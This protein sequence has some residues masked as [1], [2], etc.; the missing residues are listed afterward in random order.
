VSDTIQEST[1]TGGLTRPLEGNT[2]LLLNDPGKVWIVETGSVDL[3]AV[4][5]ADGGL[6]SARH[7]VV[8]A[9]PGAV[10]FGLDTPGS[11]I[12][13][14]AVGTVGTTIRTLA[15]DD[16]VSRATQ[17]QPL[18]A[19]SIQVDTWVSGLAS[20]L[21]DAISQQTER[22]FDSAPVVTLKD[23]EQIRPSDGVT[24]VE[25]ES[26]GALFLDTE[27]AL[28]AS[29]VGPFPLAEETWLRGQ[30]ATA[31]L[32]SGSTGSIEPGKLWRG[33][34]IYHRLVAQALD[35][36]IEAEA[37]EDTERLRQVVDYDKAVRKLALNQLAGVLHHE[38]EVGR[39]GAASDPLFEA[40]RIVADAMGIDLRQPT[41]DSTSADPN[42]DP[43]SRIARASH[44][45]TRQVTLDPNWWRVDSGSILAFA[46]DDKAP[47]ALVRTSTGRYDMVNPAAGTRTRVD[48]D[49]A[50]TLSPS[51][52]VFYR[53]FPGK[54]LGLKEIFRF[55]TT[56][57]SRDLVSIVLLGAATGLLAL[58]P[59][60]ATGE[61]FGTIIPQAEKPRLWQL[62]IV[63]ILSAVAIALFQ[64]TRSIAITRVEA[65]I[66][67]SVQPALWDRLLNLPTGF[68]RDYTAGNLA[69][70]AMGIDTA[71]QL[72][73]GTAISS[74]LGIV[75]SLFSFALLFYYNVA[76]ALIA[77]VLT[78]IA[79]VVSVFATYRQL[80]MQRKLTAIQSNITG[81]VFQYL[82]G[83]PKLR[84]AGAE[85]RAYATWAKVF[86][87][88][89]TQSMNVQKTA[90]A[91]AVFGSTWPVLGTVAIF[92]YVARSEPIT[93]STADLLAF[94]VAFAQFMAAGLLTANAVSTVLQ[95]VPLYE[96]ARP[97]LQALPEVDI[98]RTD[99]G[100]LNGEIEINHVSFRYNSDGPLALNNVTI[101]IQPGQFVA[102]VGPSGA[103]K[104]SIFRLLL[105]FES[106]ENGSIYF[107]GQ[108]V[109]GI[110]PE[111]LRRQMGVVT[112]DSKVLPGSIFVNI[113]GATLLTLDDAWEAARLAGL[114]EDIRQMPMGMQTVVSEGGATFSGGQL[115]RLMIARAIVRRPRILLF[116]EATSA[117]DNRTQTIVSRSLEQLQATR[118]VIAHRLSTIQNADL[119]YVIEGGRVTQTGRYSDLIDAPGPF[120]ELAK[121]Q[122]A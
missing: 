88:Q 122:L 77:S 107:D 39:L 81:M 76:L 80:A 56:G 53:P 15:R 102:L 101:K 100:T 33:L 44:I 8:T 67:A 90:N 86:A 106:P 78:V 89:K 91:F 38:P 71:R 65:R 13:L 45:R 41:A 42:Q 1:A 93:M 118:V 79:V 20:G 66:D 68:F 83:I 31:I 40:S 43:L 54:A 96:Q 62:A 28:T 82:T 16:L 59:P 17:S 115:Q 104:S 114:D 29:G 116:D 32:N 48:R 49:L 21:G 52:W 11:G 6:A 99:P 109:S 23:G 35:Q 60:L 84:V 85:D 103:G 108:D 57:S 117:L 37:L 27:P 72:L 61:L 24:W 9:A 97:I 12:A 94:L 51:A 113:V 75:F 4:Q 2:P 95:C 87:G 111:A 92:A 50:A 3:F 55:A 7:H 70:R 112:Q 19:F 105:G 69:S 119:I 64:V 47:V 46:G 30:G 74:L 18:S 25:I 120:A 121:R 14:L 26:G 22:Q 36:R 58:L 34:D 63:L 10:L 5:L 98:T 73:T 110:D